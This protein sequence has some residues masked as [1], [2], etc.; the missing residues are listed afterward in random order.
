MLEKIISLIENSPSSFNGAKNIK[1]EL[2]SR[3]YKKITFNES[4]EKGGK[5]YIEKNES[6]IL[7][8]NIGESLVNP[9]F[10]IVASHLDCP[11]FKI[12]PNP[13]IKA[14]GYCKLNVEGYGGMIMSTWLDKPLGIAGRV[15]YKKDGKI[16]TEIINIDE[17]VCSIP[18]VAIHMN[19][20]VNKGYAFNIKILIFINFWL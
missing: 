19:R 10:N 13:V 1:E 2:I 4:I 17:A 12:K 3:G 8:F 15:A 6:C 7:A 18:N 5:Y 16:V 9:Y 20:E 11:S 14:N